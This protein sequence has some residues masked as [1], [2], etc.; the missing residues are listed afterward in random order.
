MGHF[1]SRD[2]VGQYGSNGKLESPATASFIV[3]RC[4]PVTARS[5]ETRVPWMSYWTHPVSP[6]A[7]LHEDPETRLTNKHSPAALLP[8]AYISLWF[9]YSLA[10][11]FFACAARV[12]EAGVIVVCRPA[13]MFLPVSALAI[14]VLQP[15]SLLSSQPRRRVGASITEQADVSRNS[16]HTALSPVHH[17]CARCWR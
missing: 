16:L 2:A 8:R 13:A 11:T 14:C 1:V 17:P 15:W 12:A 3:G 9:S 10:W 5:L 4:S 6:H 7:V